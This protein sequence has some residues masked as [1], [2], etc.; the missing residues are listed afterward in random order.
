M[1]SLCNP[2]ITIISTS[3]CY[4]LNSHL[5]GNYTRS[6]E[7]TMPYLNILEGLHVKRVHVFLQQRKKLRSLWRLLWVFVLHLLALLLH[8]M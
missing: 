8:Y 7:S 2:L 5:Q 1:A 4:L 6:K 3:P